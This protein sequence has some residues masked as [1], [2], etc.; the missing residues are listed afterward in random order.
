MSRA[1][2]AAFA[3]GALV[4]LSWLPAR[5]QDAE[6]QPTCRLIR[7]ASLDMG[8]D[9]TGGATLSASIRDHP[10]TLL[11]DTGGFVTMFTE[12][13]VTALGIPSEVV[14]Q[15]GLYIYGG[16]PLRRFAHVSEFRLGRMKVGAMDFPLL[17]PNF[18]PPDLDGIIAPDLLYNFDV[19]FDFAN[20]KLNLFSK[21]HCEGKVIY[22]TRN[23]AA[24]VKIP[25]RTDDALHFVFPV[26]LDGKEVEA[27]LDTGAS[28]SGLS[29]DTAEDLFDLKEDSPSMRHVS[30][31]NGIKDAY[32][33]PFK[34]LSFDGVTVDHPDILMVSDRDSKMGGAR[35]KLIIGMN[36]LRHLHL[37]IA[38]HERTLYLSDATLH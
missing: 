14:P 23:A 25:V 15:S 33:Y 20:A 31:P 3:A 27:T 21:D 6:P 7:L 26:E 29:L 17:P 9:S 4:C 16:I 30:G 13:T 18:L 36:V 32:I 12:S 5:A 28:G 34:T 8:T 2:S 24:V 11:V 35:A 22:W 19:D 10:V 37:Y 38:Y 1:L